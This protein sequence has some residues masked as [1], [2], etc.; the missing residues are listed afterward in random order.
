VGEIH[1]SD[2]VLHV[3]AL[4]CHASC[5]ML[6][7]NVSGPISPNQIICSPSVVSKSVE[8]KRAIPSRLLTL[9][10]RTKGDYYTELALGEVYGMYALL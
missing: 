8:A 2:I 1:I 3:A 10:L 7:L 5:L 9:N 4:K 6:S